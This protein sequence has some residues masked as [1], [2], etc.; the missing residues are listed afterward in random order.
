MSDLEQALAGAA[1]RETFRRFAAW[2]MHML[3]VGGADVTRFGG[4]VDCTKCLHPKPH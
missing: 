1:E 4:F 3:N 2:A